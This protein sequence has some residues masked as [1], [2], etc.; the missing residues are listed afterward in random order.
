MFSWFERLIEPFPDDDRT[1]PR[2]NLWRFVVFHAKPVWPLLVAMAVLTALISIIEVSL[3]AFL[4][5]IVDWFETGERE[6]FMADN[7]AALTGMAIVVLVLLPLLVFIEGLVTFQ[8]L[9]GNFPMRFRWQ[10]HRWLLNQSLGFFQDEFAGRIATKLM[11]T[12]LAVRETVM[13]FLDV[14]L[15][16][17]VYFTGIVV[18]VAGADWRLAMPFLVWLAGYVALLRYFVPRLGRIAERQADARAQMTGRVVDAYTNI[19]TVKL[20]AH[21]R[22][23]A[24]HAR[25]SMRA[26]L[27]TVYA[28][29]RRIN[30]FYASLY[31][32]N[33]L[34]LS[35]VAALG[36][37]LWQSA[38][39]SAGAVAAAI[40][41]VLRING[42]AQWIMWEVSQLFE[43]IGTLR[44]GMATFSRPQSID[45][46][47]GAPPL[48]VHAGAIRFDDVHFH[49]G[50]GAGVIDGFSLAIAPGEK[51]GLVG[52]SGAG[53]STLLSLL[54][55]F[56]DVEGG[57][58]FIDDQN[59]AA[60]TQES[61]RANIGMVTQDTALLHRS[62]G[63]NIRYGRPDAT[64]AEI[65]AA[66]E[67]AHAREFIDD[68]VDVHGHRGLDAR[69]GER[70]VK[71]S[72]GQRQ[73][74]ALARVML[75]NAP[76]L[77]L[78]EATSA[79]DSEIEAAITENLHRLMAGKTVIAVAH[80]LSTIAALDRLVVIDEG[81]IVET[82]SH[83]ELLAAN[84]LYAK[85]WALQ[86]GGFL[87][88]DLDVRAA[89]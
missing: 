80:R 1:P 36:I 30:A 68:L 48:A 84:G 62:V 38:L 39:I 83:A 51:V 88:E 42:M 60:V 5:H 77:L 3:F 61:L 64:D 86:S 67:A 63:D 7:G 9:S 43:N 25:R 65:A 33:S 72:G 2:G 73:R 89:R 20:F 32:L 57:A 18:L 21:T 45:D 66:L 10:V 40:G 53:K 76:I 47:P 58:I 70:G 79:L 19:A 34:L 59:I 28:Q 12:A 49:Y 16:V 15:Y 75:K 22:R 27:D 74:V 81:A 37:G 41:L 55:R 44:D 46:A 13:K 35:A 85:L 4:G 87:A 6:T 78:D 26:F 8:A 56:H 82:G 52:R 14:M 50:R 17:A 11:Q 54:L 31:V 23:E 69:V 29:M 71:L 24:G